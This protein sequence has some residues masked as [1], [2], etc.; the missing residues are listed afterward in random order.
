MKT[1]L[2]LIRN[3]YLMSVLAMLAWLI[4]FDKNDVFTQVD[5]IH[6]CNKLKLEKEYYQQEIRNNREGLEDLRQNANTLEKFAREKY[7]MKKDNEDLF[8]FVVR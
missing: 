7:L 5:L 8:V 4:F 3:K 1:F 2:N 6:K